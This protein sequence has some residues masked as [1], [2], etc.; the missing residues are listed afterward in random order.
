MNSLMM[1]YIMI[2]LIETYKPSYQKLRIQ[3]IQIFIQHKKNKKN[4]YQ[5]TWLVKILTFYRKIMNSNLIFITYHL[6]KKS[7]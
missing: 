5:L 4:L 2:S 1:K 3:R 6:L 7:Y